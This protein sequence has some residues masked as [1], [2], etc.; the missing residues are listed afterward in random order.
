M[1]F[2]KVIVASALIFLSLNSFARAP[3]VKELENS[4]DKGNA[5]ACFDLG[6]SYA[7]GYGVD[8]FTQKRMPFLKNPDE[9]GK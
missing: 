1:K 6:V 8:Q 5:G 2:H 4:C 7:E 3:S 9:L